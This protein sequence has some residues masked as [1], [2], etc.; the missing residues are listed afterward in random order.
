[1]S[2]PII[3]MF[4]GAMGLDLGLE[5]AGL[6]TRLALEYDKDTCRTIRLNRPELPLLEG[7]IREYTASD[8]LGASGLEEGGVFLLCGG[9]PCQAF[10]TAGRRN[11]FNDERGN[12]FLKF[13]ELAIEI[14]PKYLLIEN[15]RGLLSAPLV[16]RP[17]AKRGLEYPPL[18]PEEEKGGALLHIIEMLEAAGYALTFTLYNSAN[19]GAPQI[20]ERVIILGNREGSR[21]PLI[22]PTHS[23]DGEGGLERWRTLREAIGDIQGTEMQCD[24]FPEKRLVYY[25]MLTRGQNWRD[26]P[27]DMQRE[28]LGRSFFAGGGK[29]GF[30]RRLAWDKPSPTLV[31]CPTMPATDLCHPDEDRPLS[32]EEYKRIQEFPDDWKLAGNLKSQYRQI[33]NAVPVSLARSAGR[34]LLWFDGL[35]EAEY[36]SFPVID[37]SCQYSRY[38]NTDHEHFGFLRQMAEQAQLDI[39]EE[40]AV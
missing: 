38:R 10:S 31:T 25:R 36:D 33:G 11:G 13:I 15:V 1:M 27:E 18:S 4:T 2:K 39:F 35:A 19:Y 6:E 21:L 9:P 26:L 23:Q 7:D 40:E 30:F 14:Q 3:S 37:R 32:V 20:R 34:H 29:T 24:K 17:H 12:V 28:A 16:H 22:P 5:A 8:I